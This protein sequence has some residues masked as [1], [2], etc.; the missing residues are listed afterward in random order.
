MRQ[1]RNMM[2]A[3]ICLFV[4]VCLDFAAAV[5]LALTVAA[6][7]WIVNNFPMLSGG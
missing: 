7:R 6:I 2:D 3:A 4:T 1:L 5:A